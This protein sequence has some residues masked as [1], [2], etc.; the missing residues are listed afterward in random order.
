MAELLNT[1]V[2]KRNAYRELVNK[3]EGSLNRINFDYKVNIVYLLS[4]EI[5]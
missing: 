3:L 5:G 2:A 4:V 1:V